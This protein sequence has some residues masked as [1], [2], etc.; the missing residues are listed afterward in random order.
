MPKTW[1][2]QL[3]Q[4]DPETGVTPEGVAVA[5]LFGS[6]IFMIAGSRAWAPAVANRQT[7]PAI[8]KRFMRSL[9]RCQSFGA[10]PF[11]DS[12]SHI[13]KAQIGRVWVFGLRN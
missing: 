3:E 2:W 7:I 1:F 6:Y 13:K 12:C 11:I 9:L 4:E 8:A 10:T 5:R